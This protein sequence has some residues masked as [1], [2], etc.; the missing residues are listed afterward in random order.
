MHSIF[1]NL[2]PKWEVS[3][4]IKWLHRILVSGAN[5]TFTFIIILLKYLN[6]FMKR[7]RYIQ[8]AGARSIDNSAY[9][10]QQFLRDREKFIKIP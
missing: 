6:Y 2:M 1:S 5:L 7:I 3:K 8:M 9:F 10:D 4:I